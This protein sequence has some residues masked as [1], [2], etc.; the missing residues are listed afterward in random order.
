[1]LASAVYLVLV[2]G[3]RAS[4]GLTAAPVQGWAYWLKATLVLALVIGGIVA[5]LLVVLKAAGIRYPVPQV[6]PAEVVPALWRM[7]VRAPVIEEATY[8]LVLCAP[9]A[10]LLRPWGAV[11]VSGVLFALVHVVYGNPGPDN[12]VA[13]FFLAWAFLKSGTVL[14]PVILHGLGNAFALSTHVGAWALGVE[15]FP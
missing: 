1:L 12:Q 4:L 5:L 6:P 13:G 2:R 7:C 14:V 8:R 9:L 10:A 3:D 11:A 15:M